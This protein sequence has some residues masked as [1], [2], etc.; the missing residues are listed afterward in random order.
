MSKKGET[1]L[2]VYDLIYERISQGRPAPTVR[3]ICSAL[4]LK[5][6]STAHLHLANLKNEGYIDFDPNLQRTVRL[7]GK[8]PEKTRA[9]RKK[10]AAE[11]E[12]LRLA[13]ST[14]K[15]PVICTL[16]DHASMRAGEKVKRSMDIAKELIKDAEADS[17][18]LLAAGK[19]GLVSEGIYPNDLLIVINTEA[20][21]GDIVAV[22][23]DGEAIELLKLH[24]ADSSSSAILG[25]VIG[26]IRSF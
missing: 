8:T 19:E 16:K 24:D 11:K 4:H 26:L 2:A 12:K 1:R 15:L 22:N 17:A 7:T 6:T 20:R 21:N 10:A 25:K 23:R 9:F 5:S 14:V 3:E 13:P 18:F